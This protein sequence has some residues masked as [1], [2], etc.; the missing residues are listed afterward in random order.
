MMKAPLRLHSPYRLGAAFSRVSLRPGL[1]VSSTFSSAILTPHLRAPQHRSFHVGPYIQA[2]CETA[3]DAILTIHDF[4]GLPWAFAI[5]LVALG[6]N[7]LFRLPST[8]HSQLLLQRRSKVAAVLQGWFMKLYRD[9]VREKVPPGQMKK[10]IEKRAKSQSKRIYRALGLQQWKMFSALIGVPFWLL[11]LEGIR[12]LCGWS[13]WDSVLNGAPGAAAETRAPAIAAIE[14]GTIVEASQSAAEGITDTTST[15][16]PPVADAAAVTDVASGAAQISSAAPALEPTL[17][18]EGMLWFTDLTAADPY[19]ILPVCFTALTIINLIPKDEAARRALF[20]RLHA[21]LKRRGHGNQGASPQAGPQDL[22]TS[23]TETVQLSG[24]WRVRLIR[25]LVF[26]SP[27]LIVLTGGF[28]AAMHLYTV[29]SVLITMA[30]RSLVTRFAPLT[31]RAT[32]SKHREMPVIR[33]PLKK[34]DGSQK[35]TKNE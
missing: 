3:Q 12:R 30:S 17:T 14:N 11:S 34:K 1:A 24:G 22:T 23:P 25:T 31:A 9:A 20:P 21:F 2:G 35:A 7:L 15:F 33:P 4:T 5:P 29:T 32:T 10:E 26:F 6:V 18:S 28:P 27:G 8:I 13:R 19:Y 16:V